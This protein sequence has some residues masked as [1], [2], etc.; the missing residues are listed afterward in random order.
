MPIQVGDVLAITV[1]ALNPTSATPYN[2][3]LG[4][5][6]ITVEQD[7]RIVY[8][9]LGLLRVAGLTRSQ[10]RDLMVS[11]LRTYLTEPVVTVDFVNF[12]V[13]V[14]GEVNAQGVINVPDGK[15]NILEAIARSGDLTIYGKRF[16]VTV[17][18]ET[19]GRRE[20]GYV[21]LLSNSI[22]SS[23]Y[24]RLQQNDIVYVQADERKPTVDDQ[25]SARRFTTVT[26]VL[27]ILSTLTLLV[28]NLIRN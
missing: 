4:N 1:S 12:K 13:T 5:K 26:S 28:L 18:R 3:P 6:G 10:V 21:N 14:L 27:A 7:G 25:I 15:I 9:Q 17:V 22:F 8:P 20:F 11:R 24:Y 19:N 2:L 23:P 16:P